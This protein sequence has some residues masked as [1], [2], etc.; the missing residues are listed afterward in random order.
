MSDGHGGEKHFRS[1][2]GSRIACEVGKNAVFSFMDMIGNNGYLHDDF[3][4]NH[5]KREEMLCQLEKS[6]IQHWNESVD[7]HL[8][9]NPVEQDTEF[10]ALNDI[11]KKTVLETPAKAYG[12]TFI[13]AVVFERYFFILKLGDG[14]VCVIR[15]KNP[16]LFYGADDE[17]KDEQLQFNITTSLCNGD[18]DKEFRHCFFDVRRYRCFNGV[19]L[20][21]DGIINSYASEQSYLNF[22]RNIIKGYKEETLGSAHAELAE[23][24]PRLSEKGSGDDLTVGIIFL[25]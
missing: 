1:S 8:S 22:I 5:T 10:S 24:L 19:I 9:G 17:L 6:I 20:T 3:I 11:D 2:E 25:N 13:A 7:I 21:T 16:Y 4:F 12:A 14:N 23:F 15:R 18:A